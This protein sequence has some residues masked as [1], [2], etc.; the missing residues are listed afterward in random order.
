MVSSASSVAIS[1]SMTWRHE[2][3][4]TRRAWVSATLA[5]AVIQTFW[6]S[7]RRKDSLEASKASIVTA[8]L[9]PGWAM[10]SNKSLA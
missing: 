5:G 10:A 2:F 9:L 4:N 8:D 1:W 7:E 3:C 6:A